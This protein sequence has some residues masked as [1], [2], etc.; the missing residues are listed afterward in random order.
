[1]ACILVIDDDDSVRS[2]V[3]KHLTRAGHEVVEASDGKKAMQLLEQT[4]VDLIIADM[5]MPEMDGIEFTSRLGQQAPGA[6]IIAIS[7]G[8]HMDKEDV[9]EMAQRLGAVRTLAKPFTGAELLVAV[10]EVL[11][12]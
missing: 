8:G 10:T 3:G 4:P 11:G 2:T 6:K 1:M 9:L 12:G 7:G 5:Y